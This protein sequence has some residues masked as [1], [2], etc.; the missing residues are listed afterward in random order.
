MR[1]L[2]RDGINNLTNKQLSNYLTRL[3]EEIFGPR[4][5]NLGELDNW[6]REHT[7]DPETIDQAFVVNFRIQINDEDTEESEF[8]YVLTTIRLLGLATQALNILSDATHKTNYEGKIH[9]YMKFKHVLFLFYF[10]NA[11]VFL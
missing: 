10:S 8:H 4:E 6:C 5:L 9:S 2:A 1:Q 3:R 7:T 11:F